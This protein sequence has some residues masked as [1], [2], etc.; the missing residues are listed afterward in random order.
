MTNEV[1]L[2]D[3]ILLFTPLSLLSFGG[4]NATIPDIHRLVVDERGWMSATTFAQLFAIAQ[5]APG[6]NILFI[7]LIGFQLAGVL[8]FVAVTLAFCLPSS[9]LMY[10]LSRYWFESSSEAS[11]ARLQQAIGPQAAALVLSAGGL[12]AMG[13]VKSSSGDIDLIALGLC[14]ATV[15]VS[16]KTT[17]HPMVWIVVGALVGVIAGA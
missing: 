5:A 17:I 12:I 4:G 14:L 8:G 11:R 15:I 10:G 6:P 13:I 3:L 9:L 1:T 2:H 16:L 7:S